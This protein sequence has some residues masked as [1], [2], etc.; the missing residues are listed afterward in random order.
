[1]VQI[2]H[3]LPRKRAVPKARKSVAIGQP[4]MAVPAV[5]RPSEVNGLTTTPPLAPS[6]RATVSATENAA[7][8]IPIAD[9]SYTDQLR[10]TQHSFH[11]PLPSPFRPLDANVSKERNCPKT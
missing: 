5:G 2:F 1:M 10:A 7:T 6:E 8:M 3:A 4:S 11:P 9:K